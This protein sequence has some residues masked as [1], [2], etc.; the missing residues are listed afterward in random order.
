MPSQFHPDI[1]FTGCAGYEL[2]SS[3]KSASSCLTE[4]AFPI[5]CAITN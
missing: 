3:I 2:P 5:P 1:P 4:T